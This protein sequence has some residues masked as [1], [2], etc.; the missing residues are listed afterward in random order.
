MDDAQARLSQDVEIA[1]TMAAEM[2]T[3]VLS[4]VLFWPLSPGHM[5][6]LTLGGY[7]MRQHRLLLLRDQLT[8]AERERLSAAMDAYEA[9]AGEWVVRIEQKGHQELDARLRQWTEYLRDLREERQARAPAYYASAVEARAMIA[10]LLD[11]LGVPPFRLEAR[12]TQ[13]LDL[14]D[15]RLRAGFQAGPFVWPDGWQPAYPPESF[16]WLYGSP[17]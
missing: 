5:P 3:Y 10:A 14:L 11:Q 6:R 16:W 9:V 13:E 17:A 4:E 12:V 7:L 1:E 8:A 2:R 15:R